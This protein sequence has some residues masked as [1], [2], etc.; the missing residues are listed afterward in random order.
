MKIG[1]NLT[2][3]EPKLSSE[4]QMK[5]K[6]QKRLQ[7]LQ[8]IYLEQPLKLKTLEDYLHNNSLEKKMRKKLKLI[9]C[10]QQ[11]SQPQP[12]PDPKAEEMGF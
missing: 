11:Y 9:H 3:K 2:S 6:M 8:K 1:Y 12:Q 4:K 7:S 5:H 10:S